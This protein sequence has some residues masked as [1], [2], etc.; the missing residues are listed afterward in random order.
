MRGALAR[1]TSRAS[2]PLRQLASAV[3]EHPVLVQF[4]CEGVTISG[5]E[6]EVQM[7]ASGQPVAKLSRRFVAGD[8]KVRRR[9]PRPPRPPRLVEVRGCPLS[10]GPS[11]IR[12][13]Y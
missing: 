4:G 8:Y 10:G 1:L 6:L 9:H 2:M 5:I 13:P 11:P 7:G 3:R 12:R